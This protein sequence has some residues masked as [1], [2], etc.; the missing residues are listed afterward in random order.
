VP[1]DSSVLLLRAG[2]KSGTSSNVTSG[3]LKQSQKRTK[4]APFTEALMSS[5]PASIAG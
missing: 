1:D 5:V 4:R 2:Q 3:M